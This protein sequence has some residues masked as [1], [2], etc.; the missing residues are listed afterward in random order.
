MARK[1]EVLPAISGIQEVGGMPL[2]PFGGMV[3]GAPDITEIASREGITKRELEQEVL[4]A[5]GQ[6]GRK[7]KYRTPSEREEAA[8]ERARQ[9]REERGEFLE[10]VGIPRKKREKLSDEERAARRSARGKARRAKK[11]AEK[12]EMTAFLKEH[13]SVLQDLGLDPS[14][15][16]HFKF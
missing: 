14:K 11:K 4:Y 6:K 13:K 15:Y 3:F 12:E 8:A 16:K 1:E 9:R 2:S 5:T 10:G 7:K